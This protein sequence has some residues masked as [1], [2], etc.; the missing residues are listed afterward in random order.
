MPT[1]SAPSTFARAAETG[2]MQPPLGIAAR[3]AQ[4]ARARSGSARGAG[5]CTARPDRPPG[6]DLCA[7]PLSRNSAIATYSSV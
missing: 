7:Q 6:G 1:K 2:V 3:G 4:R 5:S